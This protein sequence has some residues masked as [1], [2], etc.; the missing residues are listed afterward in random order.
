M[1]LVQGEGARWRTSPSYLVAVPP[2]CQTSLPQPAGSERTDR[3]ARN[4]IL[5]AGVGARQTT[6]F[7]AATVGYFGTSKGALAGFVERG[8]VMTINDY[9]RLP[10]FAWQLPGKLPVTTVWLLLLTAL[11]GTAALRRFPRPAS[12]SHDEYVAA[13]GARPSDRARGYTVVA[14]IGESVRRG[15]RQYRPL[16]QRRRDCAFLTVR[17]FG[18]ILL[19]ALAAPATAAMVHAYDAYAVPERLVEIAPGR[20]LNLRCWGPRPRAGKP[21]VIF[22]SGLGFP[23]YS[24]RKVQPAV[25]R[26]ARA[27]SYDRAGLGFSDPGPLPRSAAAIASDLE[28]LV[29]TAGLKPPFVLVGSS[30]GSQSVRLFAFRRPGQVAALVLV[31]PYVEGQYAAF[32]VIAPGVLADN[33]HA[34]AS[35]TACRDL[36]LSGTVP[37]DEARRR[38]CLSAPDPEFSPKLAAVVL[39]QRLSRAR[40]EAAWSESG[41]LDTISEREIAAE[42]RPLGAMPIVVLSAGNDFAGQGYSAEVE[43]RL[44]DELSRQHRRLADLSSNGRVILVPG[45]DHVIQASHPRVVIDT[46]QHAVRH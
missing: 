38:D 41:A 30:L 20:R 42:R 37:A 28:R 33:A 3:D 4:A 43:R 25:A 18:L 17:G 46:I 22:E 11:L 14:R 35:E 39:R 9:R 6:A 32:D 31:D 34:K 19:A 16:L 29:D 7:H 1:W 44:L 24:W 40:A 5:V 8:A 10:R 23:S 27:C 45:A 13:V 12:T 36:L 26:F 15:V 21:T 2:T